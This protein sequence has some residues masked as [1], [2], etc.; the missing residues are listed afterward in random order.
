[1]LI[2]RA[3]DGTPNFQPQNFITEDELP[4]DNLLLL[5]NA[6]FKDFGN[7]LFPLDNSVNPA[8]DRELGL[9]T[10][11]ENVFEEDR[12]FCQVASQLVVLLCDASI[13]SRWIRPGGINGAKYRLVNQ[14]ESWA[15]MKEIL[16]NLPYDLVPDET[17]TST[18][19]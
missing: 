17:H 16:E 12:G 3:H 2:R 11:I 1:M 7:E 15:E 18:P 9:G 10:T 19:D 14:P 4:G 6:I 5:L 8:P 13:F